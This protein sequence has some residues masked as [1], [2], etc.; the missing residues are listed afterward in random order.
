MLTILSK[1]NNW[2]SR[3][4]SRCRQPSTL[5][6]LAAILTSVA[7]TGSLKASLPV[8]LAGISSIVIDG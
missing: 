8:I 3:I 4:M 7:Q 1:L 6:G 5:T 2:R